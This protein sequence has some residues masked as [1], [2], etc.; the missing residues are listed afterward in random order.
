M[1]SPERTRLGSIQQRL[2]AFQARMPGASTARGIYQR[3]RRHA[4]SVL[5]AGLAF[6]LFLTLLPFFLLCSA[7]LGFLGGER[8]R[9]AS[10]VEGTL[11][12]SGAVLQLI[13][14]SAVQ[15]HD[16][17]WPLL[18]AG[19]VLLAGTVS[20]AYGALR[21]VHIVAWQ[22]RPERAGMVTNALAGL[23][24]IAMLLWLALASALGTR[25]PNARLLAG[26]LLIAALG[27]T[28]LLLSML[29]PHGAAPWRALVPGAAVVAIGVGAM[30][31]ISSYYL[32]QKLSS[33]S[34]LYGALG[35]AA[36]VMTWLFLGC[37]LMVAATVLYALRWERSRIL[38]GGPTE[39]PAT[40]PEGPDPD[41]RDT[42]VDEPGGL[43][44]AGVTHRVN[45]PP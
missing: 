45:P 15:A 4:G 31:L 11:G 37:R 38:G 26:L 44:A 42:S 9:A 32:P 36:T 12:L 1:S 13:D 16:G 17:R 22:D 33:T 40:A 3:D 14:D 7:A 10:A 19:L 29:L 8:G 27:S 24:L 21:L 20:S 28:W 25:F 23:L 30:Y 34:Q 2:D 43:R 18:L 6:R 41:R 35:V 5:A 39:A